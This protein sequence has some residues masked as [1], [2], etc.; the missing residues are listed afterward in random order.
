MGWLIPAGIASASLALMY[1][2]CIRPMRS[3][4]C[5]TMF[6]ATTADGGSQE[7]AEIAELRA[8]VAALQRDLILN[9][10]AVQRPSA[11]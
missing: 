3:G 11:P 4:H 6:D 1:L 8:E 9:D 5:M 10:P 2:T 7:A